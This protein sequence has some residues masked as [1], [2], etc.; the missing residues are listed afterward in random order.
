MNTKDTVLKECENSVNK[1]KSHYSVEA[2]TTVTKACQWQYVDSLGTNQPRSA[3]DYP[4]LQ[5]A[6]GVSSGLLYHA[7]TAKEVEQLISNGN[8]KVYLL[9][10]DVV[11][12]GKWWE[13]MGSFQN[14]DLAYIEDLFP[15]DLYR[16]NFSES[17]KLVQEFYGDVWRNFAYQDNPTPPGYARVTWLPV[18]TTTG[19]EGLGNLRLKTPNPVQSDYFHEKDTFFWNQALPNILYRNTNAGINTGPNRIKSILQYLLSLLTRQRR[20]LGTQKDQ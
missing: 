10:F 5:Q 11:R 13:T 18:D 3:S 20:L 6:V 1:V 16:F 8:D 15:A 17:D 7:P 19:Q 2:R 14:L 4:W 12:E 9:S